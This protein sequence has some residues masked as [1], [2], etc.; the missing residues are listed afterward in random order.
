MRQLEGRTDSELVAACLD[1]DR[2]AF[3]QIVERY[4]RLLC[5][6][7]YAATGDISES[8]DLAQEAF[9]TAWQ[10]LGKLEEPDKLRPWLCTILRFTVSHSRRRW[11]RDPVR[12]A[13][14]L[15]EA[16]EP[17]AE[18]H[19]T[20]EKAMNKEE[21]QLLW[22]A[23]AGIPERYRE[24]LV[25]YYREEQSVRSVAVAL[26]LTESAVKQ[27]LTRGRKLL[28]DRMVAFVEGALRKSA[29]GP[30][31]TAGVIAAVA[32]LGTPAKA[33]AAG[34][35]GAVATKTSMTVK[36]VV[37]AAFMASISGVISTWIA[38]R[39]NMDQARTGRER[40]NFLMVAGLLLGSFAVLVAAVVGL[41]VAAVRWT[42]HQIGITILAQL[43]MLGFAVGWPV[44]LLSL[45]AGSRKLR[46]G[47]RERHPE[48]F[49]DPRDQ[50]GSSA[51]EYRSARTL[52][53]IPLYHFRLA[54]AE[55]GSGPVVG[56]IAG[57]DRAIGILF[58]WGG[59]AVGTISVGAL[60]GGLISLGAVS[61]GLI[62]LGSVAFGM[63]AFGA[64]AYG[65]HAIA[66]LSAVG[67]QAAQGGGFT[68]A[69]YFAEGPV[70]FAAE[71]NTFAA[72]EYFAYPHAELYILIFC[73][74]ATVM[75]LVPVSLYAWA[76]RRR[77][78]K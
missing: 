78:G 63:L 18:G 39:A 58:A 19:S 29:P 59:Y 24:P 14:A 31:F 21:Q 67:W 12:D 2:E 50:P 64:M 13:A 60:S 52:L 73:I 46:A 61:F 48:A 56:W 30:A 54:A 20:A 11:R 16:G 4:Q 15:E 77:M 68:V 5:S 42:G 22:E 71:A 51:G 25:L 57:G 69:R 32:M 62:S 66:S 75:T 41:R 47:E 8:E 27:R 36:S 9:V 45:L 44:M 35:A 34:T 43:I 37:L 72:R 33:A 26:E 55:A 76:V 3:A 49:L 74:V 70:A 65:Y 28:R 7:A 10:Q 38:I 53:G 17:S 1:G 40:R 6:L 23:L